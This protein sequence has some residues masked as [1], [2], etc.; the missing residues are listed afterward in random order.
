MGERIGFS[1]GGWLSFVLL[2]G[3]W[4]TSFAVDRHVFLD[5]EGDGILN[6]CP[7]PAHNASGA[8]G[9][10][11][12]LYCR[13]GTQASRVIGS[14][15]GRVSSTSCT[16][17][18]GTVEP[19]RNGTLVDVDHDGT[20]EPVYGHPQ[21]CVWNMAKSDSCEI[22]AGTYKKAG[23]VCD[24]DCGNQSQAGLEGSLGTCD[25]FDCFQAS[26]VAFGDGPNLDGTG[27]GTAATPGYLRGAEMDGSVDSWDPNGDKDP[28]DG[29]FP[30]ILSGDSNANGAFDRTTCTG[31]Q[32]AGD[33]FYGVII[34]CGGPTYGRHF[35]RTS[36]ESGTT[37]V[38]I[39]SDAD[40]AP[41]REI[42]VFNVASREV[43]YLQVKN[44]AFTRYNGGNGAID[45]TR[46][47]T[48]T[49]DLNGGD[50]STDGLVV[51]HVFYH[52]ND[53]TYGLDDVSSDRV[54]NEG[55]TE[56]H[57]AAF[58]DFNN[59]GCTTPTEI[60]NSF[61]VQN[62]ARLLNFD[63]APNA[64]AGCEIYFHDNRVVVDVDPA[65]VPTYVDPQGVTRTRSVV[66]GY[67]KNID[68]NPHQH[69]I[70][71]NEF[72]VKSMGTSR[73]YFMDLQA[74]GNAQGQG[75]GE[76]WVHGN[77][78]RNDPQVTQRMKRFWQGACGTEPI[79]GGGVA[80]DSYRFYFFDNTFDM[81]VPLGGVCT[82]SGELVVETNNAFLRTTDLFAS[83][84][85]TVRR[86]A[87][88]NST[89]SSD[90]AVWFDPGS[91]SS[92]NPGYHGGLANYDARISGPLDATGT[93]DPDGD[94]V[95]GV[96]YDGD[97]RND[98]VWKDTA[99]NQVSCSGASSP[100]DIGAIESRPAGDTTPPA[101]VSGLARSDR[102]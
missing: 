85:T 42:G 81:D 69:R 45:G 86:S 9:T 101:D 21:A 14:A 54:A 18:G 96:D 68:V 29:L 91:Y 67:Y 20:V 16:S 43:H 26:V 5:R 90:R 17:G 77:V 11:N 36:P 40:G 82:Q 66:V 94:G 35:C 19:V 92:G 8:S 73:G 10:E 51:D 57:W 98:T 27:Y 3:A 74:F 13:G 60:R 53:F 93:C 32:C 72:I 33:A 89:N 70:W 4:T 31:H 65:K 28:A 63:D 87:N 2:A 23:A 71:N 79:S 84:A 34:G 59:E 22:H 44:L 62:N 6:D 12:L 102:R 50:G 76:L 100:A 52:D 78:F 64:A 56:N 88:R 15:T 80:T 58:N 61:L 55:Y 7:N 83:T 97:G 48:G 95:A 30:A 24:E 38:K 49:I 46:P 41:D 1:R 25:K 47:K 75:Q 39:D 99:G 37:F